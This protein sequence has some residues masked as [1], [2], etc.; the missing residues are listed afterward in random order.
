LGKIGDWSYRLGESDLWW[1]PEIYNLLGYDPATFKTTRDAVMSLYVADGANRVLDSQAQVISTGVVQSVDVK[2]RRADGSIGDVVVMSKA[3]VGE[4]GKIT[5]FFGTIQDIS[6]RKQAEE[7]LEKLAYYDPLT[8]LAN[9]S[10]FRRELD[11][12]VKHW[13][14]TGTAGAILLLDLDRFKE[15]NDSLGHVAGDAILVKVAHL[16]SRVL[17]AD[18]FLSRLGGDEFAV[19]VRDCGDQ[20][21]VEKLAAGLIAAISDPIK[22]IMAKSISGPASELY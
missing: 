7:Q 18:H 6:E 11:D 16:F 12:A 15:I 10:L 9:R 19:V 3:L 21:L 20:A 1:A 17:S 22:R 5:G 2:V 4:G 14:A 8:G 13:R